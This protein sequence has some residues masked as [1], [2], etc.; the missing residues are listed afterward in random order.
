MRLRESSRRPRPEPTC[1]ALE[2][3]RKLLLCVCLCLSQYPCRSCLDFLLFP[4]GGGVA[5]YLPNALWYQLTDARTQAPD[6]LMSD[7]EVIVEL[8][9][10]AA[11]IDEDDELRET[12]LKVLRSNLQI[13]T[14]A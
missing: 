14:L 11:T 5:R 3:L 7:F 12:C 8:V 1:T 6:K 10:K 9:C 4:V 2:L 13:L